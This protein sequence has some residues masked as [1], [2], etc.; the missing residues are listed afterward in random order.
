MKSNK[1]VTVLYGIFRFRKAF[2]ATRRLMQDIGK[3]M[4]VKFVYNVV[5]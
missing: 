4:N 5:K 2:G 3:K 1:G